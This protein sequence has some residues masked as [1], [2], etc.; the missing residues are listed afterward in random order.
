MSALGRKQ[1]LADEVHRVQVHKSICGMPEP[2]G[3]TTRQRAHNDALSLAH[4]R[5]KQSQL[6]DIARHEKDRIEGVTLHVVHHV[7]TDVDINRLCLR[8]LL[9]LLEHTR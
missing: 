9:G 8:V 1:T 3:Y 5:L 2:W 6:I 7:N 4:H